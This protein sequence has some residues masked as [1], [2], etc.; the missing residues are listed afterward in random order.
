MRYEGDIYRPPGEWRSYLLQA[1]IGCSNNKCTFCNMYK[2]KKFR[3]RPLQEVLQDIQMYKMFHGESPERVFICDGDAIVLP[4][5]YW[6]NLLTFLYSSFDK[7]ERVTTYAGP[8]STL[9]KTPEQLKKLHE[10]GLYRAYLGVETGSDRLLKAI[11]KGCDRATMLQAGQRLREA[12]IDLWC[13]VLVGLDGTGKASEENSIE[14]AKLINEMKPQHISAMTLTPMMGTPIYDDVQAG[15]FKVLD[16]EQALLETR[17]LIENIELE[18]LHFTSNHVSNHL[19]L[20]GTLSRDRDRLIK[21]INTAI[22]EGT[23][24]RTNRDYH[25]RQL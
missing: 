25:P 15:R 7:L 16:V 10:M 17:M 18:D 14:T 1:T 22:E 9:L 2:D 12:G 8:R 11:N 20:K 4:Q 5:D 3:I 6:E 23:G 19:P 24:V 21:Q 13:T